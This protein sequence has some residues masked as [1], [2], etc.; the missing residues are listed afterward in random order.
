A[1]ISRAERAAAVELVS[2]P[3]PPADAEPADWRAELLGR[4]STVTGFLKLLP[5][6]IC[7]GANAGGAPV[8]EAMRALPEVLAY[9]SRLAAPL[10]PGHL[11]DAGVVT[12]PWRNLVF[13]HPDR[14][15]GAVNRHAYAFCV[16]EQFG[17]H[18][19]RRELYAGAST[20][21]RSPQAQL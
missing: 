16:L 14:G 2:E 17:R 15:D 8:L 19:K 18:L 3:V 12:G 7:F 10:I 11:I 5:Q 9:R 21:W 6:A 4:Y 20:R 1:G 13:G